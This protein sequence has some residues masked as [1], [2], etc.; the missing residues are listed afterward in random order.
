MRTMWEL[1]TNSTYAILHADVKFPHMP[2]Y[3]FDREKDQKSGKL[4]PEGMTLQDMLLAVPGILRVSSSQYDPYRIT[5]QK[6]HVFDWRQELCH[7]LH[8]IVHAYWLCRFAPPEAQDQQSH[9]VEPPVVA[10]EPA[11]QVETPAA[12]SGAASA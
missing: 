6:A 7:V 4:T 10:E 3:D 5:F 2:E 12:D 8:Q 9:P 1:P 11:P